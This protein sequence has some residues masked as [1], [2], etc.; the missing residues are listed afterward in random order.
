MRSRAR[1]NIHGPLGVLWHEVQLFKNCSLFGSGYAGLG[2]GRDFRRVLIGSTNDA[3]TAT[4]YF[5]GNISNNWPSWNK[6]F[7]KVENYIKTFDIANRTINGRPAFFFF[8]NELTED[9]W[10]RQ[11][12]RQKLLNWIETARPQDF[13]AIAELILEQ[14][15][16]E[17][18]LC[19]YPGFEK[20]NLGRIRI[21]IRKLAVPT[22][23]RL[24]SLI[25]V[26]G[27]EDP[28]TTLAA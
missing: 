17:Y 14:T 26:E 11:N 2:T 13:I 3:R 4:F 21:E 9:L 20:V 24:N 23:R 6:I 18:Q 12:E 25:D 1:S 5:V 16:A 28:P 22:L 27:R 8:L 7:V 19:K 15:G 10:R